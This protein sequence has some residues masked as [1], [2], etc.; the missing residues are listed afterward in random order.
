MRWNT[1]LAQGG[2]KRNKLGKYYD[3]N[4]KRYVSKQTALDRSAKKFGYK[5]YNNAKQAFKS[6][7]YSRMIRFA[8]E[9]NVKPDEKFQRLFA[10]AWN[11]KSSKKNK[12]LAQLL[13]YV[14]KINKYRSVYA[15]AL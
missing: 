10:T 13:K 7:A 8:S 15:G 12:P 9:A 11:E 1:L 3:K 2:F 4:T 14:G 6:K 5:N